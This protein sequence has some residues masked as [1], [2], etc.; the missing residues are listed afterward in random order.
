MFCE[1]IGFRLLPWELD[2]LPSDVTVYWANVIGKYMGARNENE[3][4]ARARANSKRR[5]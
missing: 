5:G 2:D 1:S 4:K 3:A